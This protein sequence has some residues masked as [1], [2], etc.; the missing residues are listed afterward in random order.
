MIN[1]GHGRVT[2]DWAISSSVPAKSFLVRAFPVFSARW[3]GG[4]AVPGM[5]RPGEGE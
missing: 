5:M 3:S 1:K 2:N 4:V